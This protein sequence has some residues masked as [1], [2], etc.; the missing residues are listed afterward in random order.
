[1]ERSPELARH[2]GPGGHPWRIAAALAAL[3]AGAPAPAAPQELIAYRL[4][5]KDLVEIQVLE[6]PTLNLERRVDDGGSLT[7]PLVGELPVGAFCMLV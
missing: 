2:G 4:G 6:E 1:M 7:L 5:P 3:L